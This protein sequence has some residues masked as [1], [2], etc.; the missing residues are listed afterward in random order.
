MFAP[1][2]GFTSV[3]RTPQTDLKLGSVLAF[4]AGRLPVVDTPPSLGMLA[5]PLAFT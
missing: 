3:Q 1:I 4:V 2:R 5:L